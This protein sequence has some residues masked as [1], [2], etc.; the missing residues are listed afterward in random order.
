MN[1]PGY[2]IDMHGLLGD[3]LPRGGLLGRRGSQPRGYG[4]TVARGN[5]LPFA[6]TAGGRT[7]L[8]VPGLLMEMWDNFQ[9]ANEYAS[10]QVPMS[11]ARVIDVTRSA[12]DLAGTGYASGLLSGAPARGLLSQNVWHG[13][14]NTWKPE[15]G[16][17]QGRPRLD[18][19][20][21]GEGAQAYGWGWYSADV[22]AVGKGYQDDLT[23]RDVITARFPD[24]T[25]M[26][27][28]EFDNLD[29]EAFKFLEMG[30]A[31]AGEFPHNTVYYAK[32]RYEDSPSSLPET[33]PNYGNTIEKIERLGKANSIGYEKDPGALYKL[34]L[35]D[36]DIA[37]YL[38]WDAPLSEQPAKLQELFKNTEVL[39]G[40]PEGRQLASAINTIKNTG[41]KTA[42]GKDIYYALTSGL[43]KE[44]ASEALRR[45]GIPGLKYYDQMS[46]P[47]NVV[48][49]QKAYDITPPERTVNGKWMVKNQDPTSKGKFFDT[50]AEAA[51]YLE[52]MPKLPP[53]TRNYVT[54]DQDVLDR[55]KILERDGE[56]FLPM[57]EASRMGRADDMGFGEVKYH[58]TTPKAE[59]KIMKGGFDTSIVGARWSDAIMPDGVFLKSSADELPG[60]GGGKQSQMEIMT[61]A[62][63]VK[64]FRD[65]SDL[66]V[67]LSK[68]DEWLLMKREQDGLKADS[69]SL[70]DAITSGETTA[71]EVLVNLLGVD[72]AEVKKMSNSD[73]LS[74]FEYI[75][76]DMSMKTSADLR[77]RA[78]V[79][80]KKDGVDAVRVAE[81]WGGPFG[82]HKTDTFIV[83]DESLLRSPKAKFDPAKR[84]SAD[85]LSSSGP[86]LGLLQEAQAAWDQFT[87]DRS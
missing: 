42:T 39:M 87:G 2:T 38:D 9:R 31:D 84:G 27:G 55:V 36:K 14:P 40:T 13:G 21:T 43:D 54:W 85:I 28:D 32:K 57:D 20:G 72:A 68:D 64:E 18:K 67:F 63:N 5:I 74:Y 33:H 30:K 29:M 7:R 52:T 25:V 26:R 24:G 66:E 50:E 19:I 1:W 48:N 34:D 60:L 23:T 6:R 47:G 69:S 35:S 17:P 45:A 22:K 51:A 58:Q 86:P 53:Q 4:A 10:G 73:A 79:I 11:E 3:G 75:V 49:W 12:L 8:A 78:T 46:R 71:K 65:R 82:E 44:A 76:K 37:K 56:T 16:F 80:F 77:A 83:L 70:F 62:K 81:D 61:R 59:K 41:N 15:P